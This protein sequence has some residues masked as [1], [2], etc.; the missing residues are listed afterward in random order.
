MEFSIDEQI[1]NLVDQALK[2][3]SS[4]DTENVATLLEQA[5]LISQPLK[6]VTF[7]LRTLREFICRKT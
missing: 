5:I 6:N 7:S 1:S 4:G 2:A 3:K